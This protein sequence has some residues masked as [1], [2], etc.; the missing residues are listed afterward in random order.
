MRTDPQ[1]ELIVW[2]TRIQ[3]NP[4]LLRL[5][6]PKRKLSAVEHGRLRMIDYLL[7]ALSGFAAWIASTIGGGGGAMLLV[8]LVG[9]IAGA[10]AIAP[11]TAVATL[12]AG[13]GRVFVFRQGIEW[14]VVA[15]A[16]PGAAIGGF[17]GAALFSTAPAEWLQVIV[18][19]FLVSTIFQYGFGMRE[20]TFEVSAWWFFPAELVVGFLS[21]LIGAMG[22]V[23]NTLYLNAGITKERMVGTKS[24]ISMPMHMVKIGGYLAFGALSGRILLFGL[25]AGV[26]ALASN[27]LARRLLRNMK[28]VSF[29]A[30]V[31]AFM[32]VS[33][34][35][36]IWQ[37]RELLLGLL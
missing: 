13:T 32:A 3:Q 19:L 35:V 9:F 17:L 16:L 34:A 37:Q 24:A 30:I 26:G 7:L 6:A 23:M 29:R 36:M 14:R 12:I 15:W 18:G 11:V 4:T 33:G 10:Q 5:T 22:P 27:W 31:V 28:E 21:G 8:P 25:A 20:R 2:K 1:F